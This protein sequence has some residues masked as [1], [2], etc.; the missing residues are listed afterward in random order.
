VQLSVER[1]N[2]PRSGRHVRAWT[3]AGSA[4]AN[5]SRLPIDLYRRLVPGRYRLSARAAG[6]AGQSPVRMLRFHVVRRSR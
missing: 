5:V 4:G 1:T 6:P 2:G 3:I